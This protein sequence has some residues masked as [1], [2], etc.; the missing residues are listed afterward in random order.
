[1]VDADQRQGALDIEL[2][3]LITTPTMRAPAV[4]PHRLSLGNARHLYWTVAQMVAHHASGGCNL[5]PGD[6]F[7]SGTISAPEQAGWG[8]LLELSMSGRRPVELGS[9][10]TRTSSRT[11]TRSS[12]APAAGAP[13]SRRS[14][15]ASAALR[16]R[17]CRC[18][19]RRKKQKNS[20]LIQGPESNLFFFVIP[21]KDGI[22]FFLLSV[23]VS[24]W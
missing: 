5:Q 23:S 1:M 11:A 8:S 21:V 24:L 9:G 17:P 3:V 14:A 2:E 15:S 7:G 4:P 10:E 13:A 16:S 6:L 18:E 22:Q 12:C 20:D 19:P